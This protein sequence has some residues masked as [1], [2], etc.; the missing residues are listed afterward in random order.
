MKYFIWTLFAVFIS[1]QGY[2]Q[3]APKNYWDSLPKP[4]GWVNDFDHL[5]TQKQN[6]TLS[7]LLQSYEERTSREITVVT[8]PKS[9]TSKERFDDLALHIANTWKMGKKAKRNGVLIVISKP[10]H[11]IRI[12]TG[13]DAAQKISNKIVKSIIDQVIIPAYKKGNYYK[14]TVDGISQIQKEFKR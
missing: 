4:S 11:R 3:T 2:G 8:L 6:A 14:G 9:A 12:E 1:Y 13:I 5:F 7:V 10:F